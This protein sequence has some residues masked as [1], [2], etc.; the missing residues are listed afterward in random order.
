M[1]PMPVGD[2]GDM[3]DGNIWVMPAEGGGLGFVFLRGFRA[4]LWK[5]RTSYKGVASWLLGRTV[6]LDK[7]LSLNL[8]KQIE[9]PRILGFAEV[10]NVVLLWTLTGIF[11]VQFELLHFKKVIKS[12]PWYSHYPFEGVY[13]A[14]K[15]KPSYLIFL[16]YYC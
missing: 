7:L 16:D 6:E 14:G 9:R 12:N 10:N 13:T 8:E 11:T 1:I 15:K 4:Q 2:T 5:R 3:R